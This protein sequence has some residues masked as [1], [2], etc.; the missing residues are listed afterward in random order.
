MRQGLGTVCIAIISISL[1][2]L[3]G[4]ALASANPCS[5]IYAGSEFKAERR[6]C[7]DVH[8]LANGDGDKSGLVQN[9]IEDAADVSPED[10]Y[11]IV[12]VFI[13]GAV[14]AIAAIGNPA[15]TAALAT[16]DAT[17]EAVAG[18]A[19]M[20][21]PTAAGDTL[22]FTGIA[23]G[24]WYPQ[25]WKLDSSSGSAPVQLSAESSRVTLNDSVTMGST[26][27]FKMMVDAAGNGPWALWQADALATRA[28]IPGSAVGPMAVLGGTLYFWRY[29][30]ASPGLWSYDG[31]QSAFV[32]SAMVDVSGFNKPHVAV[33]GG[34]IYFRSGYGSL[35]GVE[36]WK[37][38]GTAAGTK[39]V[40][41]IRPGVD[42]N[43][44]GLSSGI[45]SMTVVGDTLFFSASDGVN[46]SELWKSDGTEAGTVVLD[47]VPGVYSNG[48]AMSSWPRELTAVGDTLYFHDGMS[49]AGLWKSDGRAVGVGTVLVKQGVFPRN[50]TAVGS[51]LYFLSNG[52]LWKSDG[53]EVG[54]VLVKAFMR[55]DYMMETGS[56]LTAA[57]STLYLVA[58]D[59]VNGAEL[60]KSDGTAAGTVMVRDITS[61]PEGTFLKS[62]DYGEPDW[63]YRDSGRPQL[64]AVGG[65][66]LFFV[67]DLGFDNG[68][69]L[70]RTGP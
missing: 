19:Y 38:D 7:N 56:L 64:T 41:D 70:W 63:N 35:A 66:T 55:L 31:A 1:S 13:E 20:Y 34:N 58:D 44:Y 62:G 29:D 26:L 28:V 40:K 50:L 69:Q 45:E 21:E 65:S 9:T 15:L 27:F 54:T 3:G 22:F 68:V 43:G 11:Q 46:G 37:S 25:L 8:A 60:W 57:G 67:V 17:C 53:T 5:T 49:G 36:L 24:G 61:G 52:D 16:S 42:R 12:E 18:F 39:L 59:G 32:A 51:T 6:L 30:G 48:S 4:D 47:I 23:P 10:I 2:T 33:A 14:A